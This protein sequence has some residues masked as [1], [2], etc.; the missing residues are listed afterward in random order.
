MREWEEHVDGPLNVHTAIIDEC[1]CTAEASVGLLLRMQLRNLILVGDH[2]QLPP[3]SMVPPSELDG[4]GTPATRQLRVEFLI[5]F[6][7]C[8]RMQT[9]HTRSLLERCVLASGAVHRL[10]EQYRMHQDM[11]DVVSG[12]CIEQ[13]P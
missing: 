9:G 7:S 2:K 10:T 6:L 13:S 1:G 4:V 8:L 12:K 5:L 3:T 11:A